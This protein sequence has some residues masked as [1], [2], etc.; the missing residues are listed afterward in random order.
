MGKSDSDIAQRVAQVTSFLVGL[1][2]LSLLIYSV[3]WSQ[4]GAVIT[5][6]GAK[7]QGYH[8]VPA[9]LAFVAYLYQIGFDPR[10]GWH[11]IAGKVAI[12]STMVCLAMAT[13]NLKSGIVK[14]FYWTSEEILPVKDRSIRYLTLVSNET[15]NIHQFMIYGQLLI[16][17]LWTGYQAAKQKRFQE[18]ENHMRSGMMF[19]LGPLA[20]R[21]LFNHILGGADELATFSQ[22]GTYS[23]L[24]VLLCSAPVARYPIQITLTGALMLAILMVQNNTSALRYLLLA[25]GG[26]NYTGAINVY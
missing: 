3:E 1:N 15:V 5:S 17:Q 8:E 2:V 22:V 20:Q 7:A 4:T 25:S 10:K 23:A 14:Q 11:Q 16:H 18:H 19:L 24:M 9:I 21:F 26:E 13:K 6:T 12:F